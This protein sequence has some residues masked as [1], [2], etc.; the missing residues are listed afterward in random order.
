MA[1]RVSRRIARSIEREARRRKWTKSA[2]LR[3]IIELA[4]GGGASPEP[5]MEARHQSLLASGRATEKATLWF[6][7]HAAD[8]RGWR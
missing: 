2:V 7:E 4:F 3:E 8:S 5:A 1:V 6:I